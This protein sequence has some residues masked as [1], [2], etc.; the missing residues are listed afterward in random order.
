MYL[1]ISNIEIWGVGLFLVGLC[2]VWLFCPSYRTSPWNGMVRTN[3][4][5]RWWF[6]CVSQNSPMSKNPRCSL[7]QN[8]SM[9]IN[10][11]FS[12]ANPHLFVG[13]SAEP[14]LWPQSMHLMV[15]V[16]C[17]RPFGVLDL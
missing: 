11:Q 10:P 9:F 3:S 1:I 8:P 4:S 5:P 12:S 2:R 7:A 16:N 13:A 14:A 6:R 17:P 15:H